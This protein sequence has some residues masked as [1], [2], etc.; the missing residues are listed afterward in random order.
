MGWIGG[1]IV[2]GLVAS[3]TSIRDIGII[4]VMTLVTVNRRVSAGQRIIGIMNSKCGRG[5][6]GISGVT[7][8]T[9][10]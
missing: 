4:T 6:S 10:G 2:I 8:R 1:G 7:R 3:D 5:P 9:I